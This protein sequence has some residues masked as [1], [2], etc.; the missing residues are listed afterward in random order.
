MKV[1]KISTVIL[2]VRDDINKIIIYS[3]IYFPTHFVQI[4]KLMN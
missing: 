3:L 4:K 2:Q 1:T